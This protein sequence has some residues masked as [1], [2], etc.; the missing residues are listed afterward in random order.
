MSCSRKKAKRETEEAVEGKGRVKLNMRRTG[1][2]R[3]LIRTMAKTA[4]WEKLLCL[5][6]YQLKTEVLHR[7]KMRK[8]LK[9]CKQG[10]KS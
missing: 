6:T 3:C 1:L 5:L 2:T 9:Y 10:G 8:V 4:V 7:V